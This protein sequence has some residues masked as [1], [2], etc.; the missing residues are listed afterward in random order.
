LHAR[1]QARVS[2]FQRVKKKDTQLAPD[3]PKEPIHGDRC[4]LEKLCCFFQSRCYKI[5]AFE[6]R[7]LPI[8]ALG[9][10]ETCGKIYGRDHMD[11]HRGLGSLLSTPASRCIWIRAST[12]FLDA[13]RD[14]A[15][16]RDDPIPLPSSQASRRASLYTLASHH[17]FSSFNA[18]II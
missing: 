12:P 8:P 3:A 11:P 14:L 13:P 18:Y 5:K 9:A 10:A 2:P 17:D 16:F 6:R 7:P 1:G 15:L 4:H